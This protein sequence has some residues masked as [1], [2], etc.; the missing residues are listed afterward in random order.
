MLRGRKGNMANPEVEGGQ[1]EDHEI[2]TPATTTITTTTTD[3][4]TIR[5]VTVMVMGMIT[6]I[7]QGPKDITVSTVSTIV[8]VVT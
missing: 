3:T 1:E 6:P 8:I 4:I 5:T 2:T 7:A